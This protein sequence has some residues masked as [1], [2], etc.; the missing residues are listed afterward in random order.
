MDKLTLE[1]L[2]PYLPYKLNLL[3]SDGSIRELL[4][5][6]ISGIIPVFKPILRHFSDL[7]IEINVN[8]ERFVPKH[9]LIDKYDLKFD[10]E[11]DFF[12]DYYCIGETDSPWTGYAII[13]QLI[14]WHFDV[15][16]LIEKDLAVDINQID[17]SLL[18]SN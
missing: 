9:L 18:S 1:H 4:Y 6:D 3:Y 2:A 7:S 13:Q 5:L 12:L 15:Y 10:E 17:K 14:Q 8:G 16:G 11:D